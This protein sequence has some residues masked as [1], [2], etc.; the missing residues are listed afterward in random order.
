MYGDPESDATT[1]TEYASKTQE[2]SAEF[3]RDCAYKDESRVEE[4]KGV[5]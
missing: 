1:S 5:L 2:Y 4:G 3:I